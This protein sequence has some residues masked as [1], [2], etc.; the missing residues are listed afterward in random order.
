MTVL[1]NAFLN[2]VRMHVTAPEPV[3]EQAVKLTA[4]EFLR[5]TLTWR[6]E[7]VTLPTT[8]VGQRDYTVTN[9]PSNAALVAICAAWNGTEEVGVE[10]PGE[11]DDVSYSDTGSDWTVGVKGATTIRFSPAPSAAGVVLKAT[12]AYAPLEAATGIEDDLYYRFREAL[13]AGI[14]SRLKLQRGSTQDPKPWYDPAGA[15]P[16]RMDYDRLCLQFS[17]ATG[18]VRRRRLHVAQW[19]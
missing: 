10:I 14:V 1:W 6:V 9:N 18:P 13:E 8:V 5:D 3:L 2:K 4:I 17:S 19:G 15:M 16:W 7:N 12:C 11:S